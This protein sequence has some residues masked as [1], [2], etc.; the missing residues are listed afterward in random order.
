[1]VSDEI[2]SWCVSRTI[3]SARSSSVQRARPAGGFVQA[4]ATSSAS[5]LTESLRS[6]PGRGS[7]LSASS[8]PSSTN[9]RLVR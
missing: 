9:R 6:A 4:V 2:E 1:M 3:S 5:S 8:N 7:S